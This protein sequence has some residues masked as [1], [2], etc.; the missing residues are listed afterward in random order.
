VGGWKGVG[1]GR[2]AVMSGVLLRDFEVQHFFTK[3]VSP[4]ALQAVGCKNIVL[5]L[6]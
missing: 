4:M 5:P 1:V 3:V 2:V 6:S